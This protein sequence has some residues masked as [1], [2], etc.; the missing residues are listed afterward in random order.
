MSE[1]AYFSAIELA[2]K[3]QQREISIREAL[4]YFLVRVDHLDKPIN[5]VVTIDAERARPGGCRGRRRW[6][7][8]KC[9]GRCMAYQ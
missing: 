5:S 1:I 9:A 8:E 4:D 3:I 6:R 7:V 2:K